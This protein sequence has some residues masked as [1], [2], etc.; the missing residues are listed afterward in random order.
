MLFD[1]NNTPSS[2]PP[3]HHINSG[4]LFVAACSAAHNARASLA[5]RPTVFPVARAMLART[6]SAA[7]TGITGAAPAPTPAPTPP[8]GTAAPA[9][10][11]GAAIGCGAPPTPLAGDDING[12]NMPPPIGAPTPPPAAEAD[13][14]IGEAAAAAAGP[15]SGVAA[16]TDAAGGV[17][18]GATELPP[19]PPLDAAGGGVNGA[20]GALFNSDDDAACNG[21]SNAAGAT[22]WPPLP[23]ALEAPEPTDDDGLPREDSGDD[24]T[25]GA[26]GIP[27]PLLT[28]DDTDGDI[29]TPVPG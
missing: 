7:V 18:I 24:G 22:P 9:A 10:G 19:L 28:G 15:A 1:T 11:G 16:C 2:R 6:R 23:A 26:F 12:G 25:D 27:P 14:A 5:T 8:A 4:R 13:G 17:V 3:T 29:G 21:L 20:T